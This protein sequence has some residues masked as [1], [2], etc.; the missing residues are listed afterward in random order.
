MPLAPPHL[1][2][3]AVTVHVRHEHVGNDCVNAP[4]FQNAKRLYS[5]ASFDGLI[6]FGAK[7]RTKQFSVG[8]VVVNNEN[9]HA[10][11]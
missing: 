2:A 7:H 3:E 6:T 5:V 9:I 10:Y 8:L 4:H 1:R 11:C